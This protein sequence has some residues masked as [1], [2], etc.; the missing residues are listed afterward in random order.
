MCLAGDRSCPFWQNPAR[1]YEVAGVAIRIP[2]EVVLMLGLG[3]PERPRGRHLGHD[4]SRPKARGLD[5]GD[6]LLRDAALLLIEI[7]I[8]ER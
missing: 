8:A 2:L 6:R 3:L 4:L 1:A 7:E 5:V